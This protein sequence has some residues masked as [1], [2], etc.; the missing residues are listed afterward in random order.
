MRIAA[1]NLLQSMGLRVLCGLVHL[2]VGGPQNK[3]QDLNLV[4]NAC[5]MGNV[6]ERFVGET[7]SRSRRTRTV[8]KGS[9]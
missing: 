2:G 5:G 9:S 6:Q 7:I 8:R 3:E 1:Q 4:P